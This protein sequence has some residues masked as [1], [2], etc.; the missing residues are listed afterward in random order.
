MLQYVVDRNIYLDCVC[1]SSNT[2][3]MPMEIAIQRQD[4]DMVRTL[5]RAGHYGMFPVASSSPQHGA[6]KRW[7]AEGHSPW[8]CITSV[9]L[10]IEEDLGDVALEL[11]ENGASTE[12]MSGEISFI[13]FA[14]RKQRYSFLSNFL[15]LSEN[16]G[17]LHSLWKEMDEKTLAAFLIPKMP[18]DVRQMCGRILQQ[19]VLLR[20]RR[21]K[22]IDNGESF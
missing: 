6:S 10:A 7:L 5:L 17:Q 12:P 21:Q 20:E 22:A 1:E 9:Q 13:E 2:Q 11:L 14:R 19:K 4:R 15:N 16:I 3:R 8:C 18:D